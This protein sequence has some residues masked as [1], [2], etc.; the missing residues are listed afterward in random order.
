MKKIIFILCLILTSCLTDDQ[1]KK[2]EK[3]LEKEGFRNVKIHEY[4]LIGCERSSYDYMF[5]PTVHS[6]NGSFSARKWGR[7]IR[8]H[9]CC[10]PDFCSI[11]LK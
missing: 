6:I 3:V 8:G 10:S 9:V 1:E 2:L 4:S 5:E 11:K 7:K